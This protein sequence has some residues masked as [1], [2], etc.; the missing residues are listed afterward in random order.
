[1]TTT[2]AC[3]APAAGV[4]NY[5]VYVAAGGGLEWGLFRWNVKCTATGL[6]CAEPGVTWQV[7]QRYWLLVG[8][9]SNLRAVAW[10]TPLLVNED[11]VGRYESGGMLLPGAP[12]LKGVTS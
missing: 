6:C 2:Q 8:Y 9:D 3:W 10:S 5:A 12:T 1:M 7:G 11:A 4:N